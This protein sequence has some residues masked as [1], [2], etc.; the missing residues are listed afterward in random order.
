MYMYTS[1]RRL[2]FDFLILSAFFVFS[3]LFLTIPQAQA[4]ALIDA[5]D[6]LSTAR[7]SAKATISDA[8]SANSTQVLITDNNSIIL[9]SES[10]MLRTTADTTIGSTTIASISAQNTPTTGK[11][12]VYF[13]TAVTNPATAGDLFVVPVKAMHTFEFTTQTSIP[14]G[15]NIVITFPGSAN[16]N[17][18]PSVGSFAFNGLTG[19]D[20]KLSNAT[21]GTITVS[22]PNI[23]CDSVTSTITAGTTITIF[24]GCTAASGTS[25]TTKNPVIINPLVTISGGD[26]NKITI[27]TQDTSDSE[28]DVSFV[29]VTTGTS[30]L[31]SGTVESR[32]TF[33]LGGVSDNTAAND[34]NPG[35]SLS[36]TTNAGINARATSLTLGQ[37]QYTP[38]QKDKKISNI[39]AQLLGVSTNSLNGYVLFASS[40][41][42][43]T[44]ERGSGVFKTS[45]LADVPES[46]PSAANY[47][48]MHACGVDTPSATWTE[49]GSQNCSTVITEST[50]NECKYAWPK[51]GDDIV[52]AADYQ[53]PIGSG[54]S[55]GNGLTSVVYAA[56]IDGTI[57]AGEYT[58]TVTYTALPTF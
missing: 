53:G 37:L 30:V 38:S 51:T 1:A 36:E 33:T 22:S 14:S 5:S 35:C 52:L 54:Q 57:A 45:A 48:G 27:R 28:L 29:T 23:T 42:P 25:C 47:F 34:T 19:S 7:P 4:K 31:V 46:F 18:Y 40:N 12:T 15:G 21:C 24:V 55:A 13:K 17:S 3:F 49:A 11:R 10:A 50:A 32:F 16:N 43:L 39:T 41:A 20:I 56:G 2:F 9:A 6:T 26:E 44:H 58:T 8:M